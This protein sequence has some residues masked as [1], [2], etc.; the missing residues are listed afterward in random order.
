MSRKSGDDGRYWIGFDL[1]GTKMFAVVYDDQLKPVGQDRRST[2]GS[3]GAEAGLGRI[4]EAI[5]AALEDAKVDAGKIAGIGIGCP[6]L[7]DQKTGILRAPINLGWP[8]L[9]LRT[10]LGKRFK[11]P[12]ALLNDVDAGTFGE[13]TAGAGKGARSLLGVFPGTGVGAGFIYDGRLLVGKRHSAME[14][15]RTRWAAPGLVHGRGEWPIFEQF[16]SRLAIASNCAAETFRG[17]APVLAEKGDTD[18]RKIKSKVLAASYKANDVGTRQVIDNAIEYLSLGIA[19][20]VNL[21]GPDRIVLG[22]GLVEAMPEVFRKGVERHLKTF[23]VPE[24]AEEA[25]VK[26]AS[27][28]D[29]ATAL[30]AAAYVATEG[31]TL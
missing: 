9:P 3:E 23:A 19:N 24:L 8:D 28:G 17:N 25:S 20:A 13:F 1:G 22:G 16:C 27:L 2:Q 7:V 11:C 18:L 15:G 4:G 29:Y 21:L 6:S 5:R 31:A 10:W 26:V 14:L 30:G 12:V